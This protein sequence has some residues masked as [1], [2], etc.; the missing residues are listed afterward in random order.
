MRIL[1]IIQDFNARGEAPG[2]M[3]LGGERGFDPSMLSYDLS[4]L[5]DKNYLESESLPDE[6]YKAYTRVHFKVT[7]KGQHALEKYVSK[8]KYLATRL[9]E[10]CEMEGP[11]DELFR[12]LEDNRDL[13]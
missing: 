13:L 4:E 12:Y 1:A 5:S 9:Q 3:A 7:A 10:L 8:A 6:E 2:L 11:T